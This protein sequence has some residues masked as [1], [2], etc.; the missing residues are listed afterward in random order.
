[1][2]DEEL[3]DLTQSRAAAFE[4]GEKV[5]LR[6]DNQKVGVVTQ[7]IPH[8]SGQLRY[9]VFHGPD[10]R[11]YDEKQLVFYRGV[12]EGLNDLIAAFQEGRFLALDEFRARITCER[13]AH[14]A[15]DSLYAMRAARIL[16]VPFQYKPLLRLLRADQPR[17]LI[18]DDVGVGKT[19]EAGLILKELEARGDVERVLVMCPR[20][21]VHKWRSEMRRFDEDFKILD[22][23]TLRHCLREADIDG[24]PTE[25]ARAILPMEL[26]QRQEHLLGDKRRPGL[27]TL[28]QPPRFD[29]LIIDEAHHMRNTETARY[30]AARFL[31]TIS[32]AAVMLSATPVHT[33]AENLFTIL[34]LLRTDLFPNYDTF[35]RMAEPNRYVTNAMRHV[36]TAAPEDAWRD[37]AANA[38]ESASR[39]SWGAEALVRAPQYVHWMWRLRSAEPMGDEERVTCLRDLEELHSLALVMNRTRRRDI[40]PFTQREPVTVEVP[41]TAEQ[42]SFYDNL[43]AWRRQVLEFVHGSSVADL[44]LSQIERQAA[45]CLFGVVESLAEVVRTGKVLSR[46]DSDGDDEEGEVL[47]PSEL[48][49]EAADLL[50]QARRLPP[51]DPKLDR[52]LQLLSDTLDAEDGPGKLLVFTSFRKTIA[53]LG[54]ALSND[55]TRVAVVHGGVDDDDRQTLRARFRLPR[56][57]PD[58]I[59]VLLSTEVGAEGLDYEFC[60]RLLNYDI[61]WNPMRVEQRIG[62]IDRFGQRSPKVL[63]FNFVTPSTVE[64]RV[65][66]RCYERLGIFRDTVGDL[67]EVLGETAAALK[68]LAAD[69]RLTAEQAALRAK[70]EAD[71]VTRRAD[72]QRRLEDEAPGLLGLDA[73]LVDEAQA[74]DA[75]GRFVTGEDLRDMVEGFLKEQLHGASLHSESSDSTGRV[76]ELQLRRAEHRDE[77]RSM[78]S[79]LPRSDRT[80]IELRKALAEK[81]PVR[82]TFDQELAVERREIQFVTPVHPLAR[83]AVGFWKG[84]TDPLVA[85]LS[86]TDAAIPAGRYLF[87]LERWDE[88]AARPGARLV[89][90]AVGFDNFA[91][92]DHVAERLLAAVRL[93][94]AVPEIAP[95]PVSAEAVDTLDRD[96]HELRQAAI[97]QLQETNSALVDQRLASLDLFYRGLLAQLDS[98]LSASTDPKIIR[99]KTSERDR[100]RHEHRRR[101]AELE[102]VRDADIVST[103]IA[104]GIVEVRDAV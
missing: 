33:G 61:P 14:P 50:E 97:A 8:G 73:A 51:E 65:F 25:A 74:I 22:G 60:D 75:R 88:L 78:L 16:H 54:R 77:L 79:R 92:A 52:L 39:T 12:P 99:M 98:V 23:A 27:L 38:L 95:G 24:W 19:I 58:A 69:P 7:L 21:L 17:L 90:V 11:E 42:Q 66:M 94:D 40:G 46:E 45:S 37:A 83:L 6:V 4:V 15:V 5:A 56:A 63:I 44:V 103:R 1:M 84:R 36:R 100:H 20:S 31:T 91:P 29:L 67:E 71:N 43:V 57:D 49:S 70:Q 104:M 86:L 59:D 9:R 3:A 64:E 28:E 13:L 89:P 41:F 35:Q 93:A 87:A 85:Q 2:G 48:Q 26:I 102:R 18:A 72:E 101:R 80:V 68:K 96:A 30:D 82:L 76:F 55:E 34:Q 53:Y 47:L 62:R 32:H 81:A 10:E